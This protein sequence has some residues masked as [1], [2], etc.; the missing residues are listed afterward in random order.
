MSPGLNPDLLH[1]PLFAPNAAG[2]RVA[3]IHGDD[4]IDYAELRLRV[5]AG[6]GWLTQLGCRPGDRI[7]IALPKSLA[8][9]EAMF[10]SLAAGA[11]VL[12]IDPTAPPA[13]IASILADAT[14]LL[15]F[16]TP[17]LASI[18]SEA[19][20]T[21]D[22]LRVI[23]FDGLAGW[24]HMVGDG[25]PN[26]QP[27]EID[28]AT[29]AVFYYTSGTTGKPKAIVLSHANVA[30]FAN[31][32]IAHLGLKDSDRFASHA[33]LHFDLTTLDL[34]AA[35]RLGASTVLLDDVMVKFPARVAQILEAHQ[36]SV[37]YS[38]PTALVLLLQYGALERRHLERLRLVLFAGEPFP[39]PLLRQLMQALPGRTFVNLY[40]PTETNV[41]TYHRLPAP[42]A[43]DALAIPIGMPCEHLQVMLL[44]EDGTPAGPDEVGEITVV[45]PAVMQG[46]WGNPV[47]TEST[48]VDGAPC[49]YRTGDFGKIGD[50]GLIY[51]VGRRDDLVKVRGHRIELLEIS[52]VLNQYPSVQEASAF[53]TGPEADQIVAAVEL[54]PDA[55]ADGDALMRHCAGWLPHYA[56]PH[57][58]VFVDRLPRTSTGKIDKYVMKNQYIN[59]S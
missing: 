2:P 30:S 45:G 50:D 46:Y 39:V 27:M 8:A 32:S 43:G 11:A 48:R 26:A 42:P 19:G 25:L 44:R 40:G 49:S 37:W 24:R 58:V 23:Q 34:Y 51:L 12:P 10:S 54:K 31:W 13:R 29:S 9:V 55:I 14:P 6:S 38:V 56:M 57:H 18:L 15:L 22:A 7:A 4:R 1:A 28:P 3:F 21:L 41:C 53:V 47:L 59:A 20:F 17:R 35:V 33:P 5:L 36:V 16:T 52:A